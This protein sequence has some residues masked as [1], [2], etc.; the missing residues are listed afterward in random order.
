MTEFGR[1]YRSALADYVRQ[2]GEE[3]L[4]RA[5]ELARDALERGLSL[6]QIW[7]HH[8]RAAKKRVIAADPE[9]AA[10]FIVEF[11]AVYDMVLRRYQQNI[12]NLS[13]EVRRGRKEKEKLDKKAVELVKQR[14]RL[15]VKVEERTRQLARQAECL[16]QAN[17]KLQKINRELDDIIYVA[18]HDLLEPVRA[19][20]FHC[21][22]LSEELAE[23]GSTDAAASLERIPK[24]CLQ[25]NK[26]IDAL[27]V[28][29]KITQQAEICSP[30][31]LHAVI[32]DYARDFDTTTLPGAAG[33][34]E[35]DENLPVVASQ[36]SLIGLL[37]SHL[38]D[39]GLRFNT[40]DEPVVS[41]LGVSNGAGPGKTH[42]CVRD[43]GIGIDQAYRDEAFRMFKRLNKPERF[44]S[45]AGVGLTLARR[46]VEM[47]GGEIWLEDNPAGGT[48]VHFTLEAE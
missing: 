26:L 17:H 38:I 44:Q 12:S 22:V 48:E 1:S 27:S 41:V 29:S 40:S 18:C 24:L 45:G 3:N 34:L 20:T 46:I 35:I 10:N 39:N 7:Q 4:L 13:E 47:H 2:P 43:N 42:I 30:V 21:E 32:S 28:F 5:N 25:M 15:D 33:Q 16:H 36:P 9:A 14:D 11:L 8:H 31:D 6:T 37:F 23:T 19:I